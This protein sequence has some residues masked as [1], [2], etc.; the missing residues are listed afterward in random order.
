VKL[1]AVK[2]FTYMIKQMDDISIFNKNMHIKVTFDLK[3]QNLVQ[4]LVTAYDGFLI[5][6]IIN[7]YFTGICM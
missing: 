7:N 1:F 6:L 4:L 5:V 2:L 3:F